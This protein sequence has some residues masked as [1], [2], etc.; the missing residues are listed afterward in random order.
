MT[1]FENLLEQYNYQLPEELVALEPVS[2]RDHAKLLIYNRKTKGV[3]HDIF[4]N[5]DKHLPPN[6]VLVFNKTKVIPSRIP[7]T[8]STGAKLFL[9]YVETVD[10]T[11][12]VMATKQ[13]FEG[14]ILYINAKLYFTVVVDEAKYFR[15]KPSF[16]ISKLFSVLNKHGKTQLPPYLMGSKLSEHDL[17][18]K[19][20]AVFAKTNGSIA[21]PTASLHFTN[22]LISKLKKKRIKIEYVTLHVN[23]GTF[24]YLTEEHVKNQKLHEEYYEIEKKTITQ[25]LKYKKENRPIIAVGTTV[26]RTLESFAKT[27][28]T[29]DTTD[30]FIRHPYDFQFINGMVTNFHVPKSS[31]LMLVAAF[32]GRTKL[33]KLY[34][35]AIQNNYRFYSFGDGML[36]F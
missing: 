11:I 34:E 3:E 24:A 10:D 15:L 22:R 21:A 29:V 8:K 5:L 32:V 28:N 23:L 17:R 7:V 18:N 12:R 1:S 9:T 31:L 20:Q 33:L 27:N 25:L 14:N 35:E 26:V 36:L 16:P 19:Y 13:L 4:L 6:S 30:L 2:P